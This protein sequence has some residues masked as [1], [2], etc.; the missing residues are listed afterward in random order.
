MSKTDSI[1]SEFFTKNRYKLVE[2]LSGGLVVLSAYQEMQLS[3]DEAAAFVQEANFWYLTGIDE[4]GWQLV[5]DGS[6]HKSWLIAPEISETQ[7]LF[8]GV[9]DDDLIKTRSGAD[10][11]ISKDEGESLL[12]ELSKKHPIAYTVGKPDFAKYVSFNL[13]PAQGELFDHLSRIFHTVHDCRSELNKLRSIKQQPEIKAIKNAISIT[14]RVF[15]EVKTKLPELRH[16]YEIA[17]E[18]DYAFRNKQSTHAY[19][20]IVAG[21]KRACTLHYSDNNMSLPKKGVVLLDIGAR[22]GGY[23]ADITRTYA[24][25]QPAKRQIE[26]HSALVESHNKI[27]N[28]LSAG[29]P[30]RDYLE[31]VDE[32]MIDTLRILGLVKG[33]PIKAVR[34]YFPHAISHGLGIDVHDSLGRPRNFE[35]GMVLTVEPGIYIPEE[36]IGMRV[37][38]D[39]LITEKGRQNLSRTLSTDL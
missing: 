13:N 6:R 15:E 25:G 26:V 5:V 19:H 37:E 23:C 8:D 4:P 20:P 34:K 32:I 11:I 29:L 12:R 28:L 16:E 14:N 10:K 7:A 17:A 24:L 22:S 33:D 31:S 30:L 18:F 3:N 27:I 1:N 38:D 35:T 36:G 39:I 2:K 9:S 21:G